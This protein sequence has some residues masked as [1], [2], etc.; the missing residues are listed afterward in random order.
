MPSPPSV[1]YRVVGHDE[2]CD[3]SEYGRIRCLGGE[4]YEAGK[5]AWENLKDARAWA[6]GNASAPFYRPPVRILRIELHSGANLG[7]GPVFLG[8]RLDRIGPA[9]MIPVEILAT[10]TAHEVT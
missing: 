10:A 9:W 7:F 3:F 8:P 4:S 6:N 2:W 1:F 5:C